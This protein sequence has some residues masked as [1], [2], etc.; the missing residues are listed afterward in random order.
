MSSTLPGEHKRENQPPAEPG[1]LWRCTITS[2]MVKVAG[3]GN[4]AE[5][6][7]RSA[8][9][10]YE[11]GRRRMFQIGEQSPVE[12]LRDTV[13]DCLRLHQEALGRGG[14]L[15]PFDVMPWHALA[16]QQRDVW[17]TKADFYFDW[18]KGNGEV[19]IRGYDAHGADTART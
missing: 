13:A 6:A 11:D 8:E 9:H 18:R 15:Q 17:R 5:E 14:R 1:G 10:Y 7:E 2:H 12:H 4:S 16:E 19:P 3:H